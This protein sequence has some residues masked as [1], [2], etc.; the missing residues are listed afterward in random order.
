MFYPAPVLIP[1]CPSPTCIATLYQPPPATFHPCPLP[2][3]P[4][5]ILPGGAGTQSVLLCRAGNCCFQQHPAHILWCV[6]FCDCQKVPNATRRLVL[7]TLCAL[8]LGCHTST[9]TELHHSNTLARASRD[10]P[11]KLLLNIARV[12]KTGAGC[13]YMETSISCFKPC[14]MPM[15]NT[16]QYLF[17]PTSVSIWA[18]Q[19]N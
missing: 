17:S 8:G 7:V 18:P 12:S 13:G 15:A 10:N 9:G 14:R 4:W 1:I 5:V 16:V 19:E 11:V 6:M 3:T 2:L